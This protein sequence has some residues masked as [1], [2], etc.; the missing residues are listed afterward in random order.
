MESELNDWIF[1]FAHALILSVFFLAGVLATVL[2]QETY[3]RIVGRFLPL[4]KRPR[5]GLA[6]QRRLAGLVLAFMGL[7]ALRADFSSV[8]RPGAASHAHA[9]AKASGGGISL[10][11]LP[12]VMG[13][14]IVSA[15]FFVAMNP[16]VL[17]RWCERTLFPES[18]IAESVLRT[19]RLVFRVAGALMVLSSTG[20]F[21]LWVRG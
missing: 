1:L 4:G 8:N 3:A 12:F 2:P 16:E 7:Y 9:I 21:T 14:V 17:L 18:E 15:G 10:H 19:W 20:L 11:W 6:V 13:L 5:T